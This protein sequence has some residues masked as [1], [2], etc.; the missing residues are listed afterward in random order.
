MTIAL[1]VEGRKTISKGS[2]SF[3]AAG[4][5]GFTLKLPAKAKLG[6]YTLTVTFT[7][8]SGKVVSKKL[9]VKLRR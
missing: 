4:R 6:G 8:A 1:A 2:L 3:K 5:S 7:P 9:A